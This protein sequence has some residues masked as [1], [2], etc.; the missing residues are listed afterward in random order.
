MADSVISRLK[1]AWNI[2]SGRKNSRDDISNEN[3]NDS[4]SYLYGVVSS[5]F[6]PD[7]VRLTR[8]NERSIINSIYNRIAVDVSALTINHV[9]LDNSDRF[10]EIVDS[11]LNRCFTLSANIDQTGRAFI[12]DAVLSMLDEGCVAL[13]PVETMGSLNDDSSSFKILSIRTGRIVEWY[14]DRVRV[15]LYDDRDGQRKEIV[16]LKRN[17]AIIENPMYS[18]M[19]EPNSTLRRLIRKLNILDVV[20]EKTASGKFNMIVQLPYVVRGEKRRQEAAERQK[21]LED[22][23]N[24]SEYGVAYIDSAEKIIQL[25]RP[26]ENNLLSQIE[27]LTNLLYGQIGIT[28]AVMDG[29]ANEQEMLNYTNRAIE[30]I[31][32]AICDE[33]KRK[34]LTKTAIA[35]KQSIMFFRDPFKLVPIANIAEIADKFT[36]NEIM[37]KNEVRQG[38][39]MKPSDDPRADELRNSNIS[40][41]KDRIQAISNPGDTST[42][43][44]YKSSG[45]SF[46]ESVLTQTIH[47][48]GNSQNG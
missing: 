36:R 20:D 48:G 39:G 47:E 17:C 34:F 42:D 1:S 12:H 27:Y 13:V 22:Q 37:T 16:V 24:G 18:V 25:N 33:C 23:I 6:R 40:E 30:P 43:V 45:E 2:F 26:L 4:Y 11:S 35:Q 15:D 31:V 7:R 38:I 9:R 19:N 32:S 46:V 10:K 44:S 41:S 14:P 21:L 8:G 29:T 5:A 28:K 3:A